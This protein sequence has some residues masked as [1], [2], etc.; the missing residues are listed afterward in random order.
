[1]DNPA[2]TVVRVGLTAGTS[3]TGDRSFVEDM[4]QTARQ[5]TALSL[6]TDEFRCPIP[7]G[8]LARAIWELVGLGRPGL[9]HLAGHERLSRWEIGQLLA[10]WYPELKPHIKPGSVR[11]YVGPVRPADLSMKCDKLQRLLS[12]PLPGFRQWLSEPLQPGHDDWDKQEP[13]L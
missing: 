6:F 4:L 2:H 1:L 9:Y 5:G 8:P 12:F 10:R 13:S 7:A 3:P 11:H